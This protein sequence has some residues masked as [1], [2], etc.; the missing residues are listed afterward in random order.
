M[1]GR[2]QLKGVKK[3]RHNSKAGNRR[4]AKSKKTVAEKRRLRLLR[5]D[6]LLTENLRFQ[7]DLNKKPCLG[8]AC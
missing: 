3:N 1:A 8:M 6:V 7:N 4:R 2:K 5:Q